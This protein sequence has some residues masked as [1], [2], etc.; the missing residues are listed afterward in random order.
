MKQK[1]ESQLSL[2]DM[3]ENTYSHKTTLAKNNHFLNF[4]LRSFQK[5]YNPVDHVFRTVKDESRTVYWIVMIT[6]ALGFICLAGLAID[7]RTLMALVFGLNHL[8]S[9]FLSVYIF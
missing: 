6:F 4:L 2:M 1:T 9:R 8:S 7:D 5:L 3:N